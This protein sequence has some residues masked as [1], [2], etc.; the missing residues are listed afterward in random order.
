MQHGVCE[1]DRVALT[2]TVCSD[3]QGLGGGNV[4][5]NDEVAQWITQLL[6]PEAKS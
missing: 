5:V 4:T 1:L 6:S 3:L 2:F